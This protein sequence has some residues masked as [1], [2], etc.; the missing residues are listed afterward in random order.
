MG[1][2]GAADPDRTL[3]EEPR[4]DDTHL[5][6]VFGQIEPAPIQTAGLRVVLDSVN[7][8]GC[9]GGKR[10]LS[11]L[12]CDLVHL[13]DEPTGRFAHAPEPTR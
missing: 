6:R 9:T 3:V 4:G 5:A 7:G 12:G 1:E 8:A 11:M 2:C 13:N 10:L